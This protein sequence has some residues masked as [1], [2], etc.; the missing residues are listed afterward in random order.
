MLRQSWDGGSGG[1][2]PVFLAPYGDPDDPAR[3]AR[4]RV[5]CAT[6]GLRNQVPQRTFSARCLGKVQDWNAEDAVPEVQAMA[7]FR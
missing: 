2:R 5:T 7:I 3:S 6:D 4:I 1:G